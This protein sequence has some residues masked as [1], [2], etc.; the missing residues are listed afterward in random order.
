MIDNYA[1]FGGW[2]LPKSP[3][4][5]A[6]SMVDDFDDFGRQKVKRPVRNDGPF[7]FESGRC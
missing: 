4:G 7:R 2:K 6:L 3:A 1:I 5:V